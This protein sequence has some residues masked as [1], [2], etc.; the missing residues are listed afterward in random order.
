MISGDNFYSSVSDCWWFTGNP[1]VNKENRFTWLIDK[2]RFPLFPGDCE[3]SISVSAPVYLN[4]DSISLPKSVGKKT[5][6]LQPG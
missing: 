2:T 4:P 6:A 1:Q 3:I 5:P